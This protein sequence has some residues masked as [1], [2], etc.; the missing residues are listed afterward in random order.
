MSYSVDLANS[1]LTAFGKESGLLNV[2][3]DILERA[4]GPYLVIYVVHPTERIFSA[5]QATYQHFPQG[6]TFQNRATIKRVKPIPGDRLVLPESRLLRSKLAESLTVDRYSFETSDFIDRYIRSVFGLEEQVTANGNHAIFGRR[7][8]GKSS[9]LA[10]AMYQRSVEK[11]PYAWLAMQA[12]AGRNDLP[13]IADTL[14]EIL[15]QLKLFDQSSV[16]LFILLERLEDLGNS[17]KISEHAL[18]M[19]LPKIRRAIE[20]ISNRYGSITVFL[21]DLHVVHRSL[22]PLL[23]SKIYSV[24]RGNRVY[25]KLS[26]IEQFTHLWDTESRQGLEPPHDIQVLRLDYN[27][28]MPEKSLEHIQSILDAYALYSALP[29]ISFLCGAGVLGRLVWVAAGVPR[30]ALNL[31]SQAMTRATVKGQKK[32]SITSVNAAASEMAEDKLRHLETD[33]SVD[34]VGIKTVL[35]KVRNF[36]VREHRTNAFLVEIRND[37]MEY[38]MIEKLVAL[39]LLHVLHEGITPRE[40]GRRY[41]GLMLD[42]GFYVGIRAAKSVELFKKIPEPLTAQELRGLPAF[43]LAS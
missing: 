6:E 2:P 12:Y 29:D 16:E 21:D 38:L 8:S 25:I 23:L 32:V 7:G 4:D 39:R 13:V 5:L 19:L 40:A 42:Y 41:K 10:Y 43:P 31:F 22:Q 1:F 34:I 3:Y 20:P 35:T 28:T 17:K 11:R 26:G 27:L 37:N 33:A 18:D 9:L 30:D 14:V 36:C 24:A 15:R